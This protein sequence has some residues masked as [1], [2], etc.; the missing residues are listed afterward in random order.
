MLSEEQIEAFASRHGQV[1][2][3][4]WS[5]HRLVFRRP[6]RADVRDYRRKGDNP[7]EKLDRIDQLL[8][9]TIVA[10]DDEQES[11]AVRALFLQFLVEYPLFGNSEKALGTINVLAGLVESEEAAQM[12]KGVSFRSSKPKSTPTVSPNGSAGGT[13]TGP[14]S[15]PS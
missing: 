10:F 8:Q 13:L 9:V 2:I 1:G 6:T 14:G 4:D 7:Q 3:I 12:G 5:G 15:P 11:N